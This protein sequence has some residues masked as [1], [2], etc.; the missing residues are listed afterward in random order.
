MSI[1][2]SKL[3]PILKPSKSKIIPSRYATISNKSQERKFVLNSSSNYSN[4]KN[5][6]QQNLKRKNQNIKQPSLSLNNKNKSKSKSKINDSSFTT[7]GNNTSRF[8]SSSKILQYNYNNKKL[9]KKKHKHRHHLHHNL[10]EELPIEKQIEN[11]E[12][13]VMRSTAD[14]ILSPKEKN[15]YI[16][17][18]LYGISE[19]YNKR[20]EKIK[21]EKFLS[22]D[23]Y[24]DKLLSI[25]AKTAT[26]NENYNNLA[27][28]L[29]EIKDINNSIKPL[30]SININKIKK[31]FFNRKEKND[32]LMTIKEFLL[33][34]KKPKDAFDE[35]EMLIQKMMSFRSTH[36][37]K[38]NKI[39]DTFPV[40]L[41]NLFEKK[42]KYHG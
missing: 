25:Y 41:K 4:Y 21:T 20:I 11:F 6:N 39:Y 30:P 23:I 22:L 31:H 7:Q 16:L 24:Q 28:N 26:D 29:K 36:S 9:P 12:K 18:G 37:K 40:H 35:E 5:L 2:N 32:K 19:R 14:V 1:F 34:N 10:L 13:R 33:K 8:L 27:Y 15:E 17:N 42:S 38:R 3:S